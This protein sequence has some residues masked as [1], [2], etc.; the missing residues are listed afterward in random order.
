VFKLVVPLLPPQTIISDPVHT[1]V[2]KALADGR[3]PDVEL[4]D[5]VLVAGLYRPPVFVSGCPPQTIISD[6]V[7]TAV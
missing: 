6:P 1:A 5:H 2:W 3:S 7:H 4:A